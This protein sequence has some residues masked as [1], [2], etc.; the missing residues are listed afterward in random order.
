[1]KDWAP[2]PVEEEAAAER[3]YKAKIVNAPPWQRAAPEPHH[4]SDAE[5]VDNAAQLSYEH[6]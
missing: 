6:K 4:R 5:I 1:M 2:A 3:A